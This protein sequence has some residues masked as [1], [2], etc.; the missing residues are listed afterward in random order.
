MM[1]SIDERLIQALRENA[2]TST[3][4]LARKLDVSR[5]TVQNRL[6]QLEDTGVIRGYTVVLGESWHQALIRAHVLIEVEQRLTA[7][8]CA[9][10]S[11]ISQITALHAI[12]GDYD[13]IVMVE[14]QGT[15]ML[16]QLLDRIS[17]MDGVIRTKSSVILETK[18]LR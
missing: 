11:A 12:S 18:L 8:V 9:R 13:L 5:A 15:E 2:R 10:L 3:T 4:E 6:R 17:A 7:A 14:T 1:R 16:S